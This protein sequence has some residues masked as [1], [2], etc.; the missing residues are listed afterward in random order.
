[1]SGPPPCPYPERVAVFIDGSNFY[2][3]VKDQRGSA[4]VDFEHL[5]SGLVN[6]RRLVRVYYYNALPRENEVLEEQEA[7]GGR[8]ED[9]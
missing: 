2:H 1:M 3:A 5:V 4:R 9:W 6:G 8:Y 7:S